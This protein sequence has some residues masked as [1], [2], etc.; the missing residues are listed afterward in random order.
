MIGHSTMQPVSEKTLRACFANASRKEVSVL[1]LPPAFDGLDWDRLDFLGWRDPKFKGRAY[2]VVPTLE[3]DPV[4][5][6]LRRAD[7]TP[8]R[9]AQCSWCNDVTLPNPVV[10]YSTRK[11]GAAGRNGATVGLLLCEDFECSRNVRRLDP[12]PYPG[13][14]REAL[15]D[16]RIDALRLRT[17]GFVGNLLAAAT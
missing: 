3:G 16:E 13:F 10:F 11:V 7:A 1:T 9:R 12:L 17:A 15:R 5:L 6:I 14:D 4:G 2:V 8:R